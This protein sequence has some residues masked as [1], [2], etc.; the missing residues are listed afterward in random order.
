MLL[1]VGVFL[2]VDVLFDDGAVCRL[3][4][5]SSSKLRD[6]ANREC[7]PDVNSPYYPGQR[8][9]DA[10]GDQPSIFETCQWLNGCWNSSRVEGTVCKVTI[11]GVFVYWVASAKL[12]ADRRL[13]RVS[14]PPS[15]QLYGSLTFVFSEAHWGAM[16]SNRIIEPYHKD[17]D[18]MINREKSSINLIN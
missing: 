2:D 9:V 5:G 11:A 14:A 8:V 3:D 13:V 17:T 6:K 10:T 18:K 1:V 4:P 12:G 7:V 16:F 15:T